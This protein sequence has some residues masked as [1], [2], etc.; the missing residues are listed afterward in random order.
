MKQ[1]TA[2]YLV[3]LKNEVHNAVTV[4]IDDTV[5]SFETDNP[6]FVRARE[7]LHAAR[8]R[9]ERVN[10]SI[11]AKDFTSDDLLNASV[12]LDQFMA[13]IRCAMR[14][15]RY[16]PDEE[17]TMRRAAEIAYQRFLDY[18][19][20]RT[21]GYSAKANKAN[22]L[23]DL[24]EQQQEELTALGIWQWIE[25]I[26]TCA[27]RVLDLVDERLAHESVKEKGAVRAAREATNAAVER[28]YTVINSLNALT[29]S[30]ELTELTKLLQ[31]I[32]NRTVRY[33]SPTSNNSDAEPDT[34]PS[35]NN[36]SHET[37]IADPM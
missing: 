34:D 19:Y 22:V 15:Y 9:E 21:D 4:Q 30:E 31:T 36:D 3:R 28:L 33:N 37:N 18:R 7:E 26:R 14:A 20:K 27:Q 25:R 1:L 29:P 6:L 10:G 13:T 24:W 23:C 11:S 12:K 8:V 35:A 17:D 2:C 16:L 5:A 32:R